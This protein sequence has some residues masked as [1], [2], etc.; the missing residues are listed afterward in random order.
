[1]VLCL[2]CVLFLPSGGKNDTQRMEP[3][4]QAKVLKELKMTD[5]WKFSYFN[6]ARMSYELPFVSWPNFARLTRFCGARPLAVGVPSWA[7]ASA[8][9][10]SS[11]ASVAA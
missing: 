8:I 3:D 5:E 4:R 2:S 11:L 7:S 6:D 1:M 9:V 10:A